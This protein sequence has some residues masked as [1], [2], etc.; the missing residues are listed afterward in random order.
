LPIPGRAIEAKLR[1]YA[2]DAEIYFERLAV[3]PLQIEMLKSP[4]RLTKATDSRAKG[5]G[6]VSMELNTTPPGTL[7]NLVRQASERHLPQ[8][9]LRVLKTAEESE[10]AI[11][12]GIVAWLQGGDA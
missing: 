2:P 7:R 3:T 4:R 8:H 11:L 12:I 6:T 1:E 10:R 9:E 5:F